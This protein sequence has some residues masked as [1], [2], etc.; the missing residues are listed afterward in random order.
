V[1]V[2]R[3]TRTRRYWLLRNTAKLLLHRTPPERGPV[4]NDPELDDAEHVLLD[5][6][7][8]VRKPFVGLVRDIDRYPYW[9]KYR[10]FLQTNDIPFE[11]YD[12][13][14]SSW[15]QEA[16]RFDMV[17]WRPMSFPHELEECRRK[18]RILE[19]QLGMLC[20][21]S[22]AEARLYEDKVTQY[23]LLK[24]HGLPVIDTFISNSEEEVLEYLTT[25]DY[26]VVWK[27][28]AGSGS[29]G[30]ELVPDRRVAER[31]VR[32]VFSI[33]G[34]RT[35]WPYA[36]QKN[37]VYLQ[38]FVPDAS[39]DLRVLVV[40]SMVFGYYRDVPKGEFRASGMRLV[41]WDP[42]PREAIVLARRV[43]RVLDLPFVAVDMLPD[44]EGNGLRIIELSTFVQVDTL[45]ELRQD[46]VAGTYVFDGESD[47]YRFSPAR[48]W[49]QEVAL[50]HVL[51]TRWL[52][53]EPRAGGEPA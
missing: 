25:C 36:G 29:V 37:Y 42:P 18:F 3:L 34:R 32:R 8:G 49:P 35:Y 50:K 12:I 5:W 17:V 19:A 28:T 27:I 38:K 23:D 6:P 2:L 52:A 45:D 40:G 11:I 48:S 13:H 14:R 30:V 51:E 39:Y 41:R 4:E 21:P 22:F 20:H 46:G 26:P 33:T 10:R 16:Q 7:A 47:D 31:W 9:T 53:R 44:A 15:L 24:Y 1:L 43:A